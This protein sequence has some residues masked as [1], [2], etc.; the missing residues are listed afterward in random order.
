MEISLISSTSIRVKG[1]HGTVVIN[2]GE[3]IGIV[4]AVILLKDAEFKPQALEQEP[5]V[6]QGPGDYEFA[7]IK[8][9]GFK[10]GEDILYS[11]RVDRVEILFG[12]LT[13]L[14]K[15]YAKLK[16]HHILLGYVD[17]EIDPSF[18]TGLATNV[19][20]FYGEKAEDAIV[21]LAKDAFRKD[22]KYVTTFEKLPQ[23]IEKIL[24][25]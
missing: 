16:E 9:T 7:G 19:I 2:P 4:N 23:E 6:I 12:R 3:K 5:L 10:N 11:I 8:V 15:D 13:I 18:V 1:K 22:G 14:E 24:L 17:Q 21:K 20:V 25:Q